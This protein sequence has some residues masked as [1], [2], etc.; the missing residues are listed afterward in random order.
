MNNMKQNDEAELETLIIYSG[1]DIWKLL[2]LVFLLILFTSHAHAD[3]GAAAHME[4]GINEIEMDKVKSGSLLFK[5]ENSDHYWQALTLETDVQID[6]TGM[7]ARTT[8]R[9]KF[10]NNQAGWVEGV[11]VFPLPE[12][13]AVDRLRMEIGDRI[14]EGEIKERSEAKRIYTEASNQGKKAS[15]IE[16]ERPNLFTNSVANIGPGETVVVEIEYQQTLRYDNGAF[17]LR[18][19][20]AITPRY[21]PGGVV[22]LEEQITQFSGSGWAIDTDQVGDASRI[23]PPVLKEAEK[24]NPVRLTVTLNSGFSLQRIQSRYHPVITKDL[25]KNVTVVTLM[26]E[27][28]KT[29]R[30][31]ELVWWPELASAPKAA[32]FTEKKEDAFYHLLMVLP[33]ADVNEGGHIDREVIY[34]IDTSGSMSGISIQQARQALGLALTRLRPED[35]FNV[36]S[37]NSYTDKLFSHARM[38]SPQ[39]IRDAQHYVSSLEAEGGTEMGSALEAALLN[40][41]ESRAVRQVIFLT[42]GS[43]GNE[44][45]LFKLIKQHLG[46]SRLFTVGIGSAPNSHFMSKAAQFG[47]GT[48]TY[49]SDLNEVQSKTAA[50]FH[51]LE[52]SVMTDLEATFDDPAAAMWPQRL[53]DLYQGESLLLTARTTLKDQEVVVT[54]QRKN[55]Q[56]S[57]T[58][59]LNNASNGSGIATLWAR[60]KIASLMDRIR[61][62][63]KETEI[64]LQVIDVALRHHLV[65]K[66]TSLVAVDVTPSHANSEIV[67]RKAVPVNLPKGQQHPKIFGRHAQTATPAQLQFLLGVLLLM[68]ALWAWFKRKPA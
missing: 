37:F 34:V 13:A 16:Q 23:T 11:Y 9:Q 48:F 42:D 32:L 4:T 20:M 40:Q 19:P 67:E 7:I 17:S 6:V 5:S 25:E 35:R 22:V 38:A 27:T 66:Y 56:W 68:L 30:D 64:K 15:L 62:G 36:I 50:L 45:A 33:P 55:H 46:N 31:F 44:A 61:D 12:D 63:D 43:V 29:D 51:K 10:K 3:S 54:G 47:R 24:G 1:D 21:I 8:L 58:L 53:P 59:H 2:W 14:I 65:S 60:N 41:Q 28:E 49:I 39:N 26:N 18:F 52:T 57:N